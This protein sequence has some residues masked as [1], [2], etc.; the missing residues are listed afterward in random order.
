MHAN[1]KFILDIFTQ[2]HQL[3]IPIYQ[4]PYSW[5]KKQ[6]E[7]LWED[8]KN[9]AK[10]DREHFIG[11]IVR[12]ENSQKEEVTIHTVIDGQQRITTILLLIS[13]MILKQENKTRAEEWQEC[14]LTNRHKEKDLFYKILLTDKDKSS[15]INIIDNNNNEIESTRIKEN[16]ELFQELLKK[17][18]LDIV[19]KGIRK[20]KIVDVV[21]DIKYDDPQLIFES[22]NSTGLKLSQADLIRNFL[23]MKLDANQQEKIY[24][25]YW[26]P[27]EKKFS[28][29]S[30][31]S[32]D[33]DI[34]FNRFFRDYLTIKNEGIIPNEG[35]VY[36]EFKIYTEKQKK[37][38]E[39]DIEIIVADIYKFS[40]FYTKI[41]YPREQENNPKLK[42][43]FIDL[44]NI[45]VNVSY[46]FLMSVYDDFS[47]KIIDEKTFLE[48]LKLIESYVF[49]R[50]ICELATNSLNKTFAN[51]H[52]SIDKDKYFDSMQS[53]L[54][55]FKNNER[56]PRDE[57]FIE[58][59]KF[60]NLYEVKHYKTYWILK[61][62]NFD[63]KEPISIENYSIEHIM[64][65]NQDKSDLPLYWQ[66][67]IGENYQQIWGK[68]LHTLGNLTL[69]AY[70]SELGNKSFADKKIF[71]DRSPLKINESIR[72]FRNWNEDAINKRAD[73]LISEMLNIWQYPVST[74]KIDDNSEEQDTRYNLSTEETFT[75][76][77]PTAIFFE[78]THKKV[79]YWQE[80][81]TEICYFFDDLSPTKFNLVMQDLPNIFA[82]QQNKDRLRAYKEFKPH[83]YVEVNKSA[84][85]IIETCQK[86]CEK[87]NY[88]PEKIEFIISTESKNKKR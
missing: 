85:N 72:N 14:F 1:Q 48:I 54:V 30:K 51:L 79:K 76:Q 56:F 74:I 41:A 44:N 73:I 11:S 27:V 58:K 86:I 57:E 7:K 25:K 23:L 62:E 84:Q 2:N 20:L 47:N 39:A 75:G 66:Q 63:R 88:D 13:A 60:K 70:N 42:Q 8:I 33:E 82:N 77:R 9:A 65:Q 6:C 43:A 10:N 29:N 71:F 45:K 49:R 81:L 67:E 34:I 40:E 21:L 46:P 53:K 17:D 18:D 31:D 24:K 50:F 4:R 64:P 5:Q 37:E 32:K 80:L 3:T 52:K 16:F 19:Y 59:L 26:Q 83:K 38:Q 55:S 15:L 36:E 28:S 22:L 12:F 68:Y 87:M 61:F 69:T 35:N 78:N